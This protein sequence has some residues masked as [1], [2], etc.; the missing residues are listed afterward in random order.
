MRQRGRCGESPLAR[1]LPGI[2]T[3][4]DGPFVWGRDVVRGTG[5]DLHGVKIRR[6]PVAL[7][8]AATPAIEAWSQHAAGLCPMGPGASAALVEAAGVA[9]RV[10]ARARELT[11]KEA[12]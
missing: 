5:P 7:A 10:N 3:D 1:D 4:A 12:E 8:D 2:R 6:C 11:R 9:E